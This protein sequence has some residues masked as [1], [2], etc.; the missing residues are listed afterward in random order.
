MHERYASE[1]EAAER[2][3]LEMAGATGI[4]EAE[5]DDVEIDDEIDDEIDEGEDEEGDDEGGHERSRLSRFVLNAAMAV[6]IVGGLTAYSRL[7]A[8]FALEE[9]QLY[10]WLWREFWTARNIQK[11]LVVIYQDLAKRHSYAQMGFSWEPRDPKYGRVED[12]LAL[13]EGKA[14]PAR[15]R[16]IMEENAYIAYYDLHTDRRVKTLV[17]DDEPGA[18]LEYAAIAA[19]A[20]NHAKA[21]QIYAELE[22]HRNTV[23]AIS[24]IANVVWDSPENKQRINAVVTFYESLI[25]TNAAELESVQGS[26]E[27]VVKQVEAF[28]RRLEMSGRRQRDYE[29]ETYMNQSEQILPYE[30]VVRP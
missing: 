7:D 19:I 27:G 20:K 12:L 29:N 10:H 30:H 26:T 3:R 15:A 6:V 13:A 8:I 21:G 1:Q 23:K 14:D 4:Y 17:P 22:K 25:R 9:T 18:A 16:A 11:S 2:D 28:R 24:N 5:V